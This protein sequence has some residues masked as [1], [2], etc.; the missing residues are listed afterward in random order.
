MDDIIQSCAKLEHFKFPE[1]LLFLTSV[2][3]GLRVIFS[4]FYCTHCILRIF[5]HQESLFYKP[6]FTQGL[7]THSQEYL[8]RAVADFSIFLGD[9]PFFSLPFSFCFPFLKTKKIYLTWMKI[10][11]ATLSE[12]FQYM[13]PVIG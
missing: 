13:L 11:S 5:Y 9:T 12:K 1:K 6:K 4:R 2:H 8:C 7:V 3:L 10:V